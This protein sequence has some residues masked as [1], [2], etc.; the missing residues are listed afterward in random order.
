MRQLH[1]KCVSEVELNYDWYDL[2]EDDA[3][4]L[5]S[6]IQ[7]DEYY[8]ANSFGEDDL[9]VVMNVLEKKRPNSMNDIPHDLFARFETFIVYQVFEHWRRK[10]GKV[11]FL[12]GSQEELINVLVFGLMHWQ[13]HSSSSNSKS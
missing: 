1:F 8:Q 7:A 10:R 3:V 2:D 5:T 13:L 6:K 12:F 11:P 9:E 4:F